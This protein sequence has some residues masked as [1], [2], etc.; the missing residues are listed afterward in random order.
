VAVRSPEYFWAETSRPTVSAPNA[1][2]ST[3]PAA[4]S[5]AFCTSG[6]NSGDG[7]V[8]EEFQRRVERFGRPHRDNRQDDQTPLHK[9]EPHGKTRSRHRDSGRQVQPRVVAANGALSRRRAAHAER[10]ARGPSR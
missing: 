1:V 7:H 5:L 8:A 10:C 9:C 3:P 2:M 4:T 6:W